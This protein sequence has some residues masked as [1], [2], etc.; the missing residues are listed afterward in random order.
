MEATRLILFFLIGSLSTFFVY[1]E[2][3]TFQRSPIMASAQ[4]TLLE[5]ENLR[6][7]TGSLLYRTVGGQLGAAR[8]KANTIRVVVATFLIFTLP[9]L[10]C[11]TRSMYSVAI[12]VSLKDCRRALSFKSF[13]WKRRI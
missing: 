11:F 4:A 7:Q 13:S 5:Q 8:E 10:M 6:G 2:I 1:A 12:V 9:W 3:P